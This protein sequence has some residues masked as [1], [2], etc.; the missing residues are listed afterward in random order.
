MKTKDKKRLRNL[1]ESSWE[2]EENEIELIMNKVT[3]IQ[4]ETEECSEDDTYTVNNISA[5]DSE[6]NLLVEIAEQPCTGSVNLL[7]LAEI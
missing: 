2:L 5:F 4:S 3:D 1:L 6:G 7:E